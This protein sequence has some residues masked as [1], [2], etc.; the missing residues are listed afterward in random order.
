LIVA[1]FDSARIIR[2]GDTPRHRV[3]IGRLSVRQNVCR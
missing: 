3:P 2:P 1:R